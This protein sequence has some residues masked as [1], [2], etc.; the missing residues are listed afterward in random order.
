MKKQLLGRTGLLVTQLGY[1]AMELR[2]ERIWD[3]RAVD[4]TK[5]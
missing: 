3:G 1:G 5:Y 2:G 4:R